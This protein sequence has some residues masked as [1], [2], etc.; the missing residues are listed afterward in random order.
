VFEI[1]NSLREARVRQR[2]EH[3][4]V[5]LGTKI[6]ARYIRALE[7]EEFG[8]LPGDTYIKGF[9]RT[10][11]DYLGLD[12]QLYVDEYGSRFTSDARDERSPERARH[13]RSRDRGVE[14]RAVVLALLGIAVLTALVIVAW[15][16]GGTDA[17]NSPQVVTTRERAPTAAGGLVLRGVGRGTYVEVRRKSGSGPVVLQATVPRGGVEKL[18]G[19]RFFLYVRHPTGVRVTLGGRA[20][21]LPAHRNLK[22]VVTPSRTVRL[23]G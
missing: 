2:L 9:L 17:S 23:A 15:K 5:E 7:Q 16:F 6:R 20:V 8:I 19:S 1:G 21:S 18:T 4:E 22:V 14:R 12:G 10:Y 3:R 11:A 13:R